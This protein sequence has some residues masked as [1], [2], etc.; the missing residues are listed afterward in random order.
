MIGKKFGK[1][2]VIEKSSIKHKFDRAYYVCKCDCGNI[3]EILGTSLTRGKSKTC[4]CSNKL[5][6]WEAGFNKLFE[7]YI[8]NSKK[9]GYNFDITKEE[10]RVLTKQKCNYCGCE[11]SQISSYGSNNGSYLHNGVD[12]VD[13]TKGY[14]IDNVVTCCEICNKMKRVMTKQQ[15][16]NHIKKI[17]SYSCLW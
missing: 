6:K 13:N 1:L 3:K 12:R 9:R 14:Q 16:F 7:T 17:V 11:P 8:N 4:G 2:I 10:F 15:F 5:C